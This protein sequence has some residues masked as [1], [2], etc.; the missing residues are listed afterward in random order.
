MI[1]AGRAT[2]FPAVTSDYYPTI[3]DFLELSVPGQMPLDGISLRP[4]IAGTATTRSSPIGFKIQSKK[5]WVNQ[6]YK[7]I[8]KGSGWLLYDLI[9]LPPGEEVEQTPL[10]TAANIASKPQA[11]QDVFNTMLAEYRAWDAAVASD[12]PYIHA[13]R[14][15]VTLETPLTTVEGPFNVTATFSKD[16]SQLHAGEFAVVN[17]TASDLSGS[18]TVWT[19][20]ITPS[21]SGQVTV[22]LPEAAAIDADGN[23]NAASNSLATSFGGME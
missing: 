9:N 10:A 11:I 16:V 21:L 2:D 13:S 14:P 17:G 8:D 3:L 15:T 22:S 6:Q 5:S 7:L 19:V 23:T 1:T 4:V 20:T 12:S 18:G